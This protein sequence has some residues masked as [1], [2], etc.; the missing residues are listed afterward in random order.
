M[1]WR[2]LLRRADELEEAAA[3]EPATEALSPVALLGT[4]GR[5]NKKG[6]NKKRKWEPGRPNRRAPSRFVWTTV[7]KYTT[8]IHVLYICIAV[9]GKVTHISRQVIG[10]MA[11]LRL[12]VFSLSPSHQIFGHMHGVLNVYKKI[13]N[14]VV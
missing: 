9:G 10:C 1:S 8:Y 12:Q 11:W 14:Y 7:Y 4:E 13:T 6:N 3:A 2:W 5:G